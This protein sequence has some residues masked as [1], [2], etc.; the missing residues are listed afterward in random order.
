MPMTLLS[1]Q[2]FC[3]EKIL[4]KTKNSFWRR[5]IIDATGK[6]FFAV[7]SLMGYWPHCRIKM[8]VSEQGHR[9]KKDLLTFKSESLL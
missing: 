1:G 6:S 7:A 9:Q 8:L 3:Q 2:L 5:V 4:K